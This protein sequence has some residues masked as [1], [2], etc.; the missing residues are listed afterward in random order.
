MMNIK[1]TVPGE[2]ILA[3]GDTITNQYGTWVSPKGRGFSEEELELI[4]QGIV[5]PAKAPG[6]GITLYGPW[7][8]YNEGESRLVLANY[9]GVAVPVGRQ[10]NHTMRRAL[11]K[12]WKP[13]HPADVSKPPEYTITTSKYGVGYVS[14]FDSCWNPVTEKSNADI[15]KTLREMILLMRS[16]GVTPI[17]YACPDWVD[18]SPVQRE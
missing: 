5:P 4:E 16:N 11:T 17:I 14:G 12:V 10:M 2:E 3:V 6:E 13:Y 18:I 7:Q 9:S 1:H 15:H 8:I